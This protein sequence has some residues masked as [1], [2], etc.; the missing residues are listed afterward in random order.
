MNNLFDYFTKIANSYIISFEKIGALSLLLFFLKKTY[1]TN[2]SIKDD[3]NNNDLDDNN[4]DNNNLD[5]NN[6]KINKN[7]YL[8]YNCSICCKRIKSYDIIYKYNDKVFC[9]HNCRKII[10]E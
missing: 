5:N 8:Y 1:M 9:S 6:L 3:L 2:K 7:N 10:D 4:L